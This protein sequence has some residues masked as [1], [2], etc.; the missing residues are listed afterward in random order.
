MTEEK[1]K[2]LSTKD[3]ITGGNDMI[4][5]KFK[6][7]EQNI[8]GVGVRAE[9]LRSELALFSNNTTYESCVYFLTPYEQGDMIVKHTRKTI[10]DL[11]DQVGLY[12]KF[13]AKDYFEAVASRLTWN[14]AA[15]QNGIVVVFVPKYPF[16]QAKKT[17]RAIRQASYGTFDFIQEDEGVIKRVFQ[18]K[19]VEKEV[20]AFTRKDPE[21]AVFTGD[22]KQSPISL[23]S[24]RFSSFVSLHGSH[25]MTLEQEIDL[26]TASNLF[27]SVF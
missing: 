6:N 12:A 11:A 23:L 13:Y 24:E 20:L 15:M 1:N 9:M 19:E 26:R 7:L 14:N 22:V 27:K 3:K 16:T 21:A 5:K 17:M 25:G 10:A 2:R 4:S 8:N 18:S